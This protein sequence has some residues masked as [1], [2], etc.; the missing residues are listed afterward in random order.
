MADRD[1]EAAADQAGQQ[2]FIIKATG[3]VIPPSDKNEKED[4]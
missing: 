3:T 1:V 2:D 4:E